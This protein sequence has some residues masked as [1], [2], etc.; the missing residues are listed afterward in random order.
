[1]NDTKAT[2]V[3]DDMSMYEDKTKTHDYDGYELDDDDD[4]DRQIFFYYGR[5]ALATGYCLDF[6]FSFTDTGNIYERYD[7]DVMIRV[8]S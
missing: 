2:P 1:M 3:R 6:F 7:W 5:W 8:S 4:N